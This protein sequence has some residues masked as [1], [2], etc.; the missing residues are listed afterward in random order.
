MAQ[1]I[2]QH[3]TT[4]SH[5]KFSLKLDALLAPRTETLELLRYGAKLNC[6]RRLYQNIFVDFKYHRFSLEKFPKYSRFP[7]TNLN[8]LSTVKV[9]FQELEF[10]E[11]AYLVI[12]LVKKCKEDLSL[13]ALKWN[14]EFLAPLIDRL[15]RILGKD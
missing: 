13:Q 5:I 4:V 3:V 9:N 7:I 6:T 8:Y 12:K 15:L 11:I 14:A 1:S 10:I 2:A